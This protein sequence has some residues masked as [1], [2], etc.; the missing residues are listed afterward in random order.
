MQLYVAYHP[1][2]RYCNR[3]GLFDQKSAIEKHARQSGAHIVHYYCEAESRKNRDLP[4][5]AGALSH[6]KR[7][8]AALIVARLDRLAHHVAFLSAVLEA[9]VEFVACDT[10]QANRDSLP[11]LL[12]IAEQDARRIAERTRA[13]L[14]RR[15]KRAKVRP[16]NLTTEAR[17]SGALSTKRKAWS[18]Y[19]PLSPIIR[20]LR[21]RGGTLRQIADHLNARGHKTRRGRLWNP[22]Q[23]KRVLDRYG[24][25]NGPD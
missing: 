12:A 17:K 1:Q 14:A 24:E 3:L 22:N 8:N 2:G 10:P 9:G 15:R 11:I 18:A 5:L 25:E 4:G 19:Q 20:E 23:V 7:C 13:G 21:A 16:D 6:A